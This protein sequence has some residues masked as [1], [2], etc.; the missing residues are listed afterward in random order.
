MCIKQH[1]EECIFRKQLITRLENDYD[2]QQLIIIKLNKILYQ[3]DEL[4]S[5][6]IFR[7]TI[8]KAYG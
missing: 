3:S 1:K 4:S 5:E 7:R 8:M 2:Y 6:Y